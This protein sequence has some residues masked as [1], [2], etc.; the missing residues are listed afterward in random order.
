MVAKTMYSFLKNKVTNA[1][2]VSHYAPRDS[3]QKYTKRQSILK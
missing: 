3:M 2:L 1:C